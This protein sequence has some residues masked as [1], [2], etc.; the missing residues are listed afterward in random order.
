MY[1]YLP[2]FDSVFPRIAA[3]V[4][5]CQFVFIGFAYPMRKLVIF[6]VRET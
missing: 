4:G 1:K 5:P 2:E 3:A 6:R